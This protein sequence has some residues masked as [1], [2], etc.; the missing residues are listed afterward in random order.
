MSELLACYYSLLSAVDERFCAIVIDAYMREKATLTIKPDVAP[1][2][3]I[4]HYISANRMEQSVYTTQTAIELLFIYTQLLTLPLLLSKV[5]ATYTLIPLIVQQSLI[6][7]LKQI[8]VDENRA[9]LMIPSSEIISEFIF[10]SDCQKIVNRH[11]L[12]RTLVFF[13]VH[14][15][16]EVKEQCLRTL[17]YMGLQYYLSIMKYVVVPNHALMHW[18]YVADEIDILRIL[19]ME[20]LSLKEPLRKLAWINVNDATAR[21]L[22]TMSLPKLYYIAN[23]AYLAKEG[24]TKK[25]L[26]FLQGDPSEEQLYPVR[27]FLRELSGFYAF[28]E[29]GEDEQPL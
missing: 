18:D 10:M 6:T 9:M 28:K 3:S 14:N 12:R 22:L 16:T 25:L 26:D 24:D 19:Q 5:S 17:E 23:Y 29:P 20:I 1:P 4:L 15:A 27:G 21:L 2:G 7:N 11:I 8:G 13:M